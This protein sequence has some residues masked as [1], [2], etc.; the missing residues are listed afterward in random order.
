MDAAHLPPHLLP[1]PVGTAT[2]SLGGICQLVRLLVQ[3]LDSFPPVHE[4]LRILLK[5]KLG[6]LD[7]LRKQ[8]QP[9]HLPSSHR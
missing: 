8:G 4:P 7:F 2:E 9:T 1:D 5:L 3:I 6:R